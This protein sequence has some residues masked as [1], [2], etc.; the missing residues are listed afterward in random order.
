[1]NHEKKYL[2]ELENATGLTEAITKAVLQKEM[3]FSYRQTIGEVLFVAI[4]CRPDIVYAIIKL[5]KYSTKPARIH[6]ITLKRI[7]RYLRDTI[8]DG[9]HYWRQDMVSSLPNVECPVVLHDNHTVDI[10]DSEPLRP[11]GFVDSDWAGDTKHR[12]SISGMCLCF[13]GAPVVYR[14]RFQTTISQSSTEAEFIAAVEL[15]KMALYL[16]ANFK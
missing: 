15:G 5:S 12:R 7:F 13:A 3:G 10:P 6:Y 2:T 1:M 16:S 4:T 11:I 14:S 8:H 9:L